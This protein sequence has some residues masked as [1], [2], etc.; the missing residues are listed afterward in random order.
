MAAGKTQGTGLHGQFPI[1][2]TDAYENRT[3]QEKLDSIINNGPADVDPAMKGIGGAPTRTTTLPSDPARRK[4][5]PIASGVLDYF[6]DALVAVAEISYA[7]NEQHNPGQPLHWNRAKSG[8]EAD[9]I[10][11]HFLQRGL[12]DSDGKRHS[13][14]MAWR[15]LAFLQ[16]EIEADNDGQQGYAEQGVGAKKEDTTQTQTEEPG[17]LSRLSKWERGL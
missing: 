12:R 3:Y 13:A 1:D 15:T 8:D 7:G 6:P 9:T 17:R 10:I 16:K 4:Q 2:R 14:K 5:F 11:R